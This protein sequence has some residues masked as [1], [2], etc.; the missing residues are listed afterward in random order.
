VA[1]LGTEGTA[2]EDTLL[3]GRAV[4]AP[5]AGPKVREFLGQGDSDWAGIG[6]PGW[7]LGVR[8]ADGLGVSR[9]GAAIRG[10]PVGVL[11]C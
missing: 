10:M 9:L 1:P 8:R 7:G 4:S 3:S 6:V 5:V 2:A 11:P